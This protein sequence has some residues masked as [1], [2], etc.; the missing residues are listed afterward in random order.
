MIV[1][2]S[3]CYSLVNWLFDAFIGCF[4]QENIFVCKFILR[5]K[6]KT[7]EHLYLKRWALTEVDKKWIIAQK[8]EM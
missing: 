6:K 1:K 4:T 2:K 3:S 5:I 8:E 7:R